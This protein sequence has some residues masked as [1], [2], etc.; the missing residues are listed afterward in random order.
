M[1]L[2]G[3]FERGETRRGILENGT[4][5][6][7][8]SRI[9]GSSG[10]QTRLEAPLFRIVDCRRIAPPHRAFFAIVLSAKLVFLH[11]DAKRGAKSRVGEI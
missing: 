9:S 3:E 8:G 5:K 1:H 2:V 4:V 11:Q 6:V 10:A 7:Y